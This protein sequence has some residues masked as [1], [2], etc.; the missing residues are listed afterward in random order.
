MRR[1][2]GPGPW[3]AQ[4]RNWVVRSFG[5]QA[6]HAFWR[7][8]NPIYGYVLLYRV[9]HPLRR[10]LP[11]SLAVWLTFVACGFVLHDLVGWALT[12]RVYF[13][14]MTLMFV[15]F[16]AGAVVSERVRMN[17]ARSPLVLRLA[18]NVAC[19]LLCW[20]LSALLAAVAPA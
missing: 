8:W 4:L 1:R 18:V 20:R 11:H 5:A 9:Y 10:W 14:E 12:R 2:I 15:L 17:L 3:Q 7:Y 13:P 6:F 19:L 16:G